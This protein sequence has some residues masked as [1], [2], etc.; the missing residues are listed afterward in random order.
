MGSSQLLY[1]ILGYAIIMIEATKFV[2]HTK[3][4]H[5]NQESQ[6]RRYLHVFSKVSQKTS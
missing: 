3:K 4:E 5:H 1:I 2:V 6:L